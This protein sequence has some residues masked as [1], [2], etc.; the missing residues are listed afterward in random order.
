MRDEESDKKV[1]KNTL[2]VQIGGSN[3]KVYHV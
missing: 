3:A 2:V 1:G